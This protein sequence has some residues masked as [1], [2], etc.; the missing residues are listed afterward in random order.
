MDATLAVVCDYANYSVDGKLNILGVF[1][2]A[3]ATG[4][5]TTVSTMYVVASF[6]ASPAEAN[7]NK[8]IDLVLLGPDGAEL[9]RTVQ[10]VTVRPSGSPGTRSIVNLIVKMEMVQFPA[11]GDYSIS[12]L[13][14]NEEK[15]SVSL[16]LL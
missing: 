13:V 4:Y 7:T 3:S 11:A 10:N 5:P 6:S 1:Q 12:I 16:R 15:R 2:Q 9:V 14:G 8:Q